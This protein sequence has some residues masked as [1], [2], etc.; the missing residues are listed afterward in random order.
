MCDALSRNTSDSIKS[1][2]C[3]CLSHGFRKFDDLKKFYPDQ[4]LHVM[5]LISTV[6]DHDAKTSHM[7]DIERLEHHQKHSAPIMD[8][9][10]QYLKSQQRLKLVEPNGALG[11]AIEYMTKH[12]YRL[13][14]FL[15]VA[16]AP[17]DNNIVERGLKIPIRARR[18][19]LFY[20][21]EYG[22]MIGAVLTSVI[23]T[24]VLSNINPLEYLITLQENKNHIVKEPHAWMPWNYEAALQRLSLA[25]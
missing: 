4:C 16:G 22:A 13:T 18:T 5:K 9:L 2:V 14:Q 8:K 24:C 20:K 25:A 23:Y 1:I 15:R 21:T 10:H 19:S 6:Y 7:S 11:K 3:Y 17:L 12:W